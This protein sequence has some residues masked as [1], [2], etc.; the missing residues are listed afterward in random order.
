MKTEGIKSLFAGSHREVPSR[1]A[2]VQS[3]DILDCWLRYHWYLNLSTIGSDR[4]HVRIRIILLF[5]EISK[6]RPFFVFVRFFQVCFEIFKEKWHVLY[7][8]VKFE[9]DIIWYFKI[10]FDIWWCTIVTKQYLHIFPQQKYPR[11]ILH[12][13]MRFV[14]WSKLIVSKLRTVTNTFNLCTLKDFTSLPTHGRINN[15]Q[16][17]ASEDFK[18]L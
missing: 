7:A 18:L 5:L 15:L 13:L 6:P 10:L 17:R 14:V 2:N 1:T 16:E 3:T 9:M 8:N 11:I 12:F 4:C